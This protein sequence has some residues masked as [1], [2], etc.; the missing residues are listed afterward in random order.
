MIWILIFYIIPYILC[1]IVGY[2]L[3]KRD[4]ETIGEY[5]IIVLFCL[6]PLMSILFLISTLYKIIKEDKTVREFLNRKL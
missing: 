2:Y 4:G 6:I 5:L 1:C 3:S